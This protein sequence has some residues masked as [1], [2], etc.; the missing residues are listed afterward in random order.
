MVIRRLLGVWGWAKK[1]CIGLYSFMDYSSL[2]KGSVQLSQWVLT[3]IFNRNEKKE[4][5][6]V[7]YYFFLRDN[8]IDC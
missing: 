8:A 5:G 1:G 2:F 7:N 3:Y 4:I 6:S